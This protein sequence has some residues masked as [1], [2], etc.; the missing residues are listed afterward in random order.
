MVLLKT[1]DVCLCICVYAY[2]CICMCVCLVKRKRS[3]MCKFHLYLSFAND[4]KRKRKLLKSIKN[5]DNISSLFFYSP[6][7]LFTVLIFVDVYLC[8]FDQL[9]IRPSPQGCSAV[10]KHP[11][12]AMPVCQQELFVCSKLFESLRCVAWIRT[13]SPSTSEHIRR[14]Q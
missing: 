2:A 9:F 4:L 8:L 6:L 11:R 13:L 14:K 7:C 1:L 12:P 3:Y 5:L 10:D